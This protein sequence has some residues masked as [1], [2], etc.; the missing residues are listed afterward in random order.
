VFGE[1]FAYHGH[2]GCWTV[3]WSLPKNASGFRVQSEGAQRK[4]KDAARGLSGEAVLDLGSRLCPP[5][6]RGGGLV[7][8][9]SYLVANGL[10]GLAMLLLGSGWKAPAGGGR[11]EGAA[12]R[13]YS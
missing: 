4:L 1:C 5:E 12:G 11:D 3:G 10:S 7:L 13:T 6:V 8:V 2:A 9:Y